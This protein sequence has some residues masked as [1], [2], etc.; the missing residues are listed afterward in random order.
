MRRTLT[1]FCVGFI[2][3]F[4]LAS[5]LF[6]TKQDDLPGKRLFENNCMSCHPMGNSPSVGP[7]IKGITQRQ[8]K[9]QIYSWIKS[10]QGHINSGDR[11][12]IRLYQ[13]YRADAPDFKFS[14]KEIEQLYLFFIENDGKASN[15]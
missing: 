14:Q 8:T 6:E 12:A 10:H 4:L 11:Y 15:N 9:K 5:M 3:L 1:I 7:G 2:T 13:E